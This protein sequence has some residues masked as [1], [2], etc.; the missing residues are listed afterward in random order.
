[1]R[2]PIFVDV[3]VAVPVVLVVPVVVVVGRSECCVR[4]GGVRWERGRRWVLE[5]GTRQ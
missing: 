4:G 2:R 5:C 1:M 3:L